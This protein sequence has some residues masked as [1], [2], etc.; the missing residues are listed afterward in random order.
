L[1]LARIDGLSGINAL[2]A[3]AAI[4]FDPHRTVMYGR[5]GAGKSG[6]ARLIANACFSR[7]TPQIV[8]NIY[9]KGEPAQAAAHFHILFDGAPEEPL[10]FTSGAEHPNLKRISFFD[11]TIAR[12][13]VSESTPFELKPSG[14]DVFPEMARVYEELGKRLAAAVQLRT[15]STRF[16]YHFHI[17]LNERYMERT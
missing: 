3:S 11:V 15:H 12:L 1:Q 7:H 6:F 10:A 8:P 17:T 14:F 5:N 2:P 13:H 9:T 4:T 16:S